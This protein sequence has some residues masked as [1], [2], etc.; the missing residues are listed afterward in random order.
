MPTPYS[1]GEG[2]GKP[3]RE[4]SRLKKG[5]G[6]LDQHAGAVAGLGIA[7]AG[8]P[9]RQVDQDFDPLQ[10]DVVGFFAG[11]VGHKANP[12]SVVL[13]ARIVKTL[14]LRQTSNGKFVAHIE[15][16]RKAARLEPA[17]TTMFP[18]GERYH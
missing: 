5:V 14:R 6:N 10:D 3:R 15:S 13:V 9:V 8:A 17:S 7:P 2:S 11:D 16:I 1:P 12:A 18:A 4:H